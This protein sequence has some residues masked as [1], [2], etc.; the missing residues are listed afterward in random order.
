MA[1]RIGLAWRMLHRDV[2]LL[3]SIDCRPWFEWIDTDSNCSD[4]LSRDDLKDRWACE[5]EWQLAEGFV[6]PW[7]AVTDLKELA[8]GTLGY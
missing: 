6:P 4:G 5:Q 2:C 8:V 1:I 3:F 7:N